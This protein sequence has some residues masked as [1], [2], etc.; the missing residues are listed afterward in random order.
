MKKILFVSVFVLFFVSIGFNGCQKIKLKETTTEDVNLLEFLRNDSTQRFTELVSIIDKI[1]YS[2]FLNAYGTYTL[3]A[4]TNK[5]INDYLKEKGVSSIQDLSKEKLKE[6]V[7]LHLLSE[8]VF[9]DDFIDGK[10]PSATME[11][12]FLVTNVKNI[13][14]KTAYIVNRQANI[15]ERDI[16]VGNGII[17]IIDAVLT[18]AKKTISELLDENSDY[19]I[20]TQALKETGYYDTL[21]RVIKINDTTTR[22]FTVIAESN[23]ALKDSGIYSYQDLKKEYSNLGEPSNPKDS[24]NLF[25]RYHILPGL[26]YMSDLVVASSHPTMVNRQVITIKIKNDSILLNDV[27]FKTIDGITHEPGVALDKENSDISASNGVIHSVVSDFSIKQRSPFPV[28]WDLCSSVPELTR[29]SNIYRKKTFLF[30]YGDGNTFEDIKWERGC[31]KYRSGVRGYLGDYWQVGFGTSTSN[32]AGLGTCPGISWI[33]FKTPL[34]IK[35]KYKVWVCY[36]TQNTS[37]KVA[38]QASFDSIPLTNALIRFSDKIA[39]ISPS[40]ASELEALG[41]KWW[42]GQNEKSGSTVARMVGI[43][44]VKQTGR[45]KIRFDL[46]SGQNPDCNL[47]MV[48]FIPVGMDQLKPRFNRDG[49]KEY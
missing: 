46:V 44:D 11:G 49:S 15:L 25:V 41:W 34:L 4:P 9:T 45:H 28:Y 42:A 36:Y 20:F 2:S 24:L 6:I 13:D 43:I 21:D 31:L 16:Q 48:H 19:S 5:A 30:D 40:R 1:G 37:K 3:F 14:G 17:D 39:S 35:G 10:L 18:P 22:W 27:E 33:E 29:L 8:E 26:K 12:Q 47:D 32:T 23:L 38:V 7:N